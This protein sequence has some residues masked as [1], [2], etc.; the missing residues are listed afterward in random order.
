MLELATKALERDFSHKNLIL[1]VIIS[2]CY[3]L[4]DNLG[5]GGARFFGKVYKLLP[6]KEDMEKATITI[7]I[8]EYRELQKYRQVDKEL[9]SDIAQGIKDILQGK[10]EEV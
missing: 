3:L 2:Y 1:N 10:I 9:L 5:W 8:E 6:V 7:P 4:Q